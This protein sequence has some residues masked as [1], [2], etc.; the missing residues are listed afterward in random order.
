MLFYTNSLLEEFGVKLKLTLSALSGCA[1]TIM[2]ALVDKWLV[3]RLNLYNQKGMFSDVVCIYVL[4][5]NNT[6]VCHKCVHPLPLLVYL[7]VL[8]YGSSVT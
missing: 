7:A 3:R 4:H 5:A 6:Q 1:N 2:V 8:G